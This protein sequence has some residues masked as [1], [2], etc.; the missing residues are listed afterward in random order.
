MAQPPPLQI[1]MSFDLQLFKFRYGEVIP[2]DE[3]EVAR[4]VSVIV[5]RKPGFVHEAKAHQNPVMVEWPDGFNLELSMQ[6]TGTCS[7][8]RISLRNLSPD[9][10]LFIFDLAMAGGMA[11]F[12]LQGNDTAASPC[13]IVIDPHQ[14]PHVPPAMCKQPACVNSGK[15]LGLLLLESFDEWSAYRRQVLGPPHREKVALGLARQ[16]FDAIAWALPVNAADALWE[17]VALAHAQHGLA[18]ALH[19]V[20]SDLDPAQCWLYFHVDVRSDGEL[21]WQAHATARTCALPD[22]FRWRRNE[23]LD[24]S[25]VYDG[26]LAYDAWLKARG[27]GFV[28][29]N[30]NSDMYA[31]FVMQLERVAD[32]QAFAAA[33]GMNC[34][35]LRPEPAGV[36]GFAFKEI[37]PSGVALEVELLSELEKARSMGRKPYVYVMASWCEPCRELVALLANAT[38]SAFFLGTHVVSLDVELWGD[39]LEAVN[40][41]PTA[42]PFITELGPDGR[43]TGRNIDGGAWDDTTPEN[44][45]NALGPYFSRI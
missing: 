30:D 34:Y 32:F 29:W 24:C 20:L 39:Q 43:S 26:L 16:V 18:H 9:I 6:Q 38:V 40:I 45:A 15:E 2:S 21:E 17:R 4:M 3:A 25:Q 44:L 13:V 33:A 42:V 14:G 36:S 35:P 19:S 23:S 37:L 41:R 31:G 7:G 11:I 8:C 22:G 28:I 1:S 10:A 12:N 27:C 5:R